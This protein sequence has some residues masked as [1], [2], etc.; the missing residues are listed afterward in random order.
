MKLIAASEDGAGIRFVAPFT[1][2]GKEIIIHET[3]EE[4]SLDSVNVIAPVLAA[5]KEM[6]ETRKIG[7]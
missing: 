1:R 6:A 3:Q 5:W 4:Y 7:D 2:S